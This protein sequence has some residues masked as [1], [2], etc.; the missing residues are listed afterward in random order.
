MENMRL[1]AA[2]AGEAKEKNTEFAEALLWLG[3]GANQEADYG[4]IE[5][6]HCAVKSYQTKD[7]GNTELIDFVCSSLVATSRQTPG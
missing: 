1:R 3:Q 6:N 2:L 4:L 5:L 7:K